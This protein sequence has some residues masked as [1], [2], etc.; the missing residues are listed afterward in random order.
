MN[1]F[2]IFVFALVAL[3]LGACSKEET[4]TSFEESQS[5]KEYT[6]SLGMTGEIEMTT[7]PLSR[8]DESTDLYGVQVYSKADV[9]GSS[10]SVCAY[11]L[12]DDPSAMS[13]K[14]LDGYLYKF[15]VT[16]VVDGKNIIY[17]YLSSYSAPFTIGSITRT[18]A[19]NTFVWDGT[20]YFYWIG[21]GYSSLTT[22]GYYRPFVDR[23]YGVA[24]DYKP[25]EDGSVSIEMKRTVFGV[26]YVAEDLTEGKLLIN[27]AEAPLVTLTPDLTEQEE[28]V[29]FNSVISAW[30]TDN[31][32]EDISVMISWVK[33]DGVTV[34]LADEPLA[35][36]RLQ[37][38]T[39]TI[40]VAD[41]SLD[42]GVSVSQ[43]S[44]DITAGASTTIDGGN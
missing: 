21:K 7:S 11:G 37:Q 40:K 6:I 23:Y 15:V 31:Y 9:D 44:G 5:P 28:I 1:R 19:D 38:H 42:A 22:G 10:Y 29:T 41:S 18:S 30:E 4:Q 26:K 34:L 39:I 25:S 17:S 13:I 36:T 32:S 20:N 14:L 16:M 8:A 2:T 35:F 33:D 43:E 12:F 27:M 3:L 24:T